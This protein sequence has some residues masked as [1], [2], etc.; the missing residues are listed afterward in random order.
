MTREIITIQLGHYANYVGAH[1]WNLQEAGFSFDSSKPS[2]INHD[3]LYREGETP[4]KEVTFTPRLLAV[5]LK[6]SLGYLNERGFLYDDPKDV[7]SLECLW[8]DGKVE[9]TAEEPIP[10]APFVHS[11]DTN[12]ASGDGKLDVTKLNFE[13]DVTSWTDYLVPR[14]H[15]RTVNIIREYKHQCKDKPFDV[16]NYGFNLLKNEEFFDEFS[17]RIR[18]YAEECDSLQGFQV[19]MD[20]TDGFSGFGSACLEYLRDEYGNSILA[21]PLIEG[22]SNEMSA[23]N[24]IKVVNTA[25]C[26]EKLGEHASLFSPLSCGEQGWP[27]PGPQRKFENLT[28]DLNLKYHTSAILATAL[29]TL[30]LRYRHKEF[31][32]S[33][34]SDLCADLNKLGRKAAATSLSLPFPMTVKNDLIDVL[35]NLEGPLW[36]SLTPSCKIIKDKSMHSLA[37]RGVNEDRLKRPLAEAKKQMEKPAYRCSSVHEMMTMYLAYSCHA[38]ACYLTTAEAPLNVPVPFPRIFN[39]NVHANGDIASWPVAEDVKSIP[40]LAGLHSGSGLAFMFNSL[41]TQ[42]SRVKSIRRFHMFEES[43]L[44][45]DDFIHCLNSLLDSKE[46]YEDNY[47]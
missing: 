43:G 37:L 10:V 29:D 6:G 39:N 33:A 1:W 34:L 46:S 47:I 15:P 17:D 41:H 27:C 28:Y 45:Q 9:I 16:F 30:S 22:G 8:E 11:L 38:S 18:Q 4:R 23:S 21:F 2:E 35:D 12:S 3:V 44:E 14:F 13:N 36:T 31:T 24:L 7:K 26:W 20:S 25:L 5:D 42:A 40:V 19:L 32:M